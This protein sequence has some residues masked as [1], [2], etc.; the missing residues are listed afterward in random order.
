[1]YKAMRDFSVSLDGLAKGLTG[2]VFA[3]LAVTAIL[4]QS[5]AAAVLG[6]VVVLLSYAFAP[7]GYVIAEGFLRVRRLAGDVRIPLDAVRGAR[8][9]AGDDLRGAIRLW[10]SGGLFGYYGLFRT[11]ALGRSWWYATHRARAVVVETREGPMVFS[12]DDVDAF[13]AALRPYGSAAVPAAQPARAGGRPLAFWIGMGVAA[14]SA[15]VVMLALLYDPGPPRYTLTPRT[16]T[17]HDRLYPVTLRVEEVD[18]AGVREVDPAAEPEWRTTARTNGFANSYYRAGWFR[19]ADGRRVRLYSA[20]GT[21]L[22]LLPPRG[23]GP[24]VLYG[25]HDPERFVRELRQAWKMA[26]GALFPAPGGAILSLGGRHDHRRSE[27]SQ[28]P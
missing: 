3:L 25:S 9:A 14:L 16:L 23:E 11:A 18:A 8:R 12:P 13:L 10:A 7:R 27:R 19:V 28:R 22:V 6:G 26:P 17:I 20:R 15:A 24:P 4:T 2:G 1:M 21:R 5:V